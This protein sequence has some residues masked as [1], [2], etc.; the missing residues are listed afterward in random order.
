MV[1]AAAIAMEALMAAVAADVPVVAADQAVALVAGATGLVGQ[2][3]LAALLTDRHYTAVHSVG[4]R[5]PAVQH[6]IKTAPPGI[7]VLLSGSMQAA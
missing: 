6:P 7:H 1:M 2:A 5:S 4:R 3:V